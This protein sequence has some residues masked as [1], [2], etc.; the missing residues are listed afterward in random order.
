M[1]RRHRYP[2]AVYTTERVLNITRDVI[3]DVLLIHGAIGRDEGDGQNVC[4]P[5]FTHRDPL[6]LYRLR[7]LTHC[8]LQLVLH[9]LYGFIRIGPGDKAQ[10]NRRPPV[11]LLCDDM[12]IRL[13]RPVIFCSMT[14]GHGV[15]QRLCRCAVIV[16]GY[17]HVG[18]GQIG[19][20]LNG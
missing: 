9:L 6:I 17:P 7:Q 11:P 3:S 16:G 2:H 19:I 13:S 12:Y 14:S 15:F 5:G 1:N 4:V 8:R 20:L 18:R 10:R